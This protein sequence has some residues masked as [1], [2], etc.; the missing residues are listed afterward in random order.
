MRVATA[1]VFVSLAL[2]AVLLAVRVASSAGEAP[3]AKPSPAK[4]TFAAGCFWCVEVAFDEVPG[5]IAT[6]AGYTGGHVQNPTYE[7][8]SSGRTG[9]AEALQVTFDPA[10]VSY[11]R[12]LDVFWRNVDPVDGDGQF[13]DRGT[14]YRPIVF[15]HDAAQKQLAEESKA[16][17]VATGRFKT[18]SPEIVPIGEFFEAEEYH[19]DFYKKNPARYKSY[20]MGCGRKRRLEEVWGKEDLQLFAEPKKSSDA[21]TAAWCKPPAKELRGTLT[22]LQYQVTQQE[23]TEAPFRNAYWDNH[24]PGI[25]VDVVSGEALF[26][27]LDKFD[28][29]SGWPSFTRPI[30]EANVT[31][32]T[33]HSLGMPRTEVRSQRGD[34]HLGHLFDD[35]PK[36]TGLRYCVNSAA[37]RFVPVTR[38]EAEGYGRYLPLFEKPPAQT[39]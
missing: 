35:G 10:K 15:Y 34:S 32:R 17:L 1:S 24:E 36:P 26:S 33:D 3:T 20:S 19:Q 8:V 27:S 4:A 6:T 11:E 21:G 37:L 28:S 29:G 9:H 13:C 7:Q 39:R 25:Y 18:L 30:A 14:Q 23:A 16:R 31:K 22:P 2:L 38:L 12:L 5:V